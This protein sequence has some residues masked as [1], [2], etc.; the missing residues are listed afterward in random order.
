MIQ[1]LSP[2][3]F[4]KY[5]TVLPDKERPSHFA[6][7]HSLALGADRTDLYQA[8]A[9]TYL[10]CEK[11]MGVLSIS[12]NGTAYETFYLD[13]PVRVHR[14]IWFGLTA[15][16]DTA[17]VQV[18]AYSL[19][20]PLHT[21]SN[22]TP[23]QILPK[24]QISC[25]YTFFY[26]EKE[27]GFLFPGEAHAMLELIY[28]DEGSVHSVVDGLDM[29]LQQGDLVLYG[30]HQWHMQ[31]ADPGIAPRLVSLCF[32]CDGYNF[33]PLYHRILRSPTKAVPLLQKMLQERE[34]E[35]LFSQ[36]MILTLLKQLLL[37]LLR[38]SKEESSIQA[39]TSLN[40]ENEIIRRAQ[41]FVADHV[42]QKLN[43]PILAQN[44]QVS[45]SYL[46]AL[47]QKHLQISPGEYIRRIKLQKSRQMIREGNLNITQISEA[48]QYS[49]I[50]H[51]SRQFKEKFDIT[52]S[53]Y[54]K[55]VRG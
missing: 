43:V 12:L 9:P 48:L 55:S 22:T 53:E 19:P 27:P 28:V 16:Q 13:R 18:A 36:D 38:E 40:N 23:F 37:T 29:T 49:T 30:P 52:P 51:F 47:F 45:P 10:R 24:L 33:S 46:T 26:Q 5:G 44:T 42:C 15:F 21:Q 50:H 34:Q 54:A 8:V 4:Q 2:E 25:L 20:R 32:D 17:S 3:R 14:G 39:S 11:G 35:D 41:Q 31:Y 7:Q 6:N 1:Q